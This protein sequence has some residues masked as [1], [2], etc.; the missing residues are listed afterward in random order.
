M[1]KPLQSL[2]ASLLVFVMFAQGC[3]APAGRAACPAPGG[4]L[5]AAGQGDP[6]CAHGPEQGL[7]QTGDEAALYLV[8]GVLLVAALTIDLLLLPFT[9]SDPFPCCRAAAS[10]CP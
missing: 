2:L 10:I 4:D 8:V 7:Q 9:G 5:V 1:P 6:D 3:V